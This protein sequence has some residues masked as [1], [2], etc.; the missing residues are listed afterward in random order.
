MVEMRGLEPLTPYM[1]KRGT[2]SGVVAHFT[3]CLMVED[4]SLVLVEL[5]RATERELATLEH[6]PATER[7]CS[8]EHADLIDAQQ[9]RNAW[10]RPENLAA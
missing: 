8:S 6:A 10:A 9:R 2:S 1:R 3:W 7:P 5:A 4:G